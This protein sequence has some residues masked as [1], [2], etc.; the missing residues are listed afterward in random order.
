ML[1]RSRLFSFLLLGFERE[2]YF[3]YCVKR[4]LH[5]LSLGGPA[6]LS[7]IQRFPN[8]ITFLYRAHI[9]IRT[10]Y[11]VSYRDISILLSVVVFGYSGAPKNM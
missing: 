10:K 3:L 4:F 2:E 8:P 5:L 6:L 7:F 9:V 11:S 1:P